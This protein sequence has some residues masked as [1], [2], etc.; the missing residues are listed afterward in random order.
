MTSW[1]NR[2]GAGAAV[3]AGVCGVL[4]AAAWAAGEGG[5]TRYQADVA[6]CQSGQSQ[7]DKATCLKEAGAAHD[8]RRTGQ[9]Q[10][11]P[12][13]TAANASARCEVLPAYQRSDCLA[14]VAGQGASSGSVDGGGVLRETTTTTYTTPAPAP[15]VQPNVQP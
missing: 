3:L 9:L 1:M 2:L 15:V 13:P 6:R 4:P 8:E 11:S 10:K 14:R 12:E 5:D 7:Q